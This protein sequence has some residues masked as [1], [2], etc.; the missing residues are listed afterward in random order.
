MQKKGIL[1]ILACTTAVG[2]FTATLL[3]N[4]SGVSLFTKAENEYS[5]TIDE[6]NISSFVQEGDV[7][8]GTFKT[9][10]GNNVTF[11]TNY[12][13]D[14][15]NDIF[16]WQRTNGYL[17]NETALTGL[18]KIEI[19]AYASSGSQGEA[20]QAV[21]LRTE[22]KIDPNQTSSVYSVDKSIK[23]SNSYS[24]DIPNNERYGNYIS[25][26]VNENYG[27]AYQLR[28]S[29]IKFYFSCSNVKNLVK[30]SSTNE[31]YG[32]V[33]IDGHDNKEIV[34]SNGSEITIHA[35]PLTNYETEY[36]ASFKGWHLNGSEEV[37]STNLDLT[38][39][40]SPNKA[41]VFEA[42]FAEAETELFDHGQT[43]ADHLD[44]Y[45]ET[46]DNKYYSLASVKDDST[47]YPTALTE[48]VNELFVA[49]HLNRDNYLTHLELNVNRKH[50]A[51]YEKFD[52]DKIQAVIFYMDME[53]EQYDPIK[54][55]RF[56]T[57][58]GTLTTYSGLKDDTD[59][60]KKMSKIVWTNFTSDQA[61]FY[62]PDEYRDP[63]NI[64]RHVIWIKRMLV[65]SR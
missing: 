57:T 32:T 11:I 30:V 53:Y 45:V 29:S 12:R 19:N 50:W 34:V 52:P 14:F 58:N 42:E 23:T 7:Y 47:S 8:R 49:H 64:I 61:I 1:T 43:T 51:N 20:P 33:S 18:Y 46:K 40:T 55:D 25:M 13:Y 17:K 59:K 56:T 16:I 31:N 26:K 38:F 28:I 54:I 41:Y 37:F 21:L 9:G 63:D 65:I 36:F 39:T 62:V 10:L 24:V 44:T 6:T 2:A 3:T 27:F 15:G 22:T 60:N 35:N 5:L 4:K 48:N